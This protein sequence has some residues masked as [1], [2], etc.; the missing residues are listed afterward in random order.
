M[1]RFD[2]GFIAGCEENIVRETW[3]EMMEEP[4][5]HNKFHVFEN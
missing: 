1:K 3:G 5:F 4:R 2:G